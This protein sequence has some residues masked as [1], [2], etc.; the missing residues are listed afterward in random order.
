[1]RKLSLTAVRAKA[2]REG[3]LRWLRSEADERAAQAGCY[4]SAR[5]ADYVTEFFPALLQHSKGQWAG[6]PFELLDWQRDELVQPLFGWL[7]PDG[8]RRYRKAFVEIPK[9]NGKSTLAAGIGLYLL[10]GDGEQGAEVY[11]AASDR[12]QAS[13]VHGEAIRMVDASDSLSLV[14]KVNRSTHVITHPDSNSVYKALSSA[15]AG[16]EGLNAHGLIIDELHVWQGRELWDALR[17]AGRARRQPLLFVITTAGDDLTS[18]CYEQYQYA[19]GV[20]DGSIVDDRFFALIYEAQPADVEADK[21]FNR[22]VWR[23]SN[24][25][26]GST[27]DEAEF[28]RD[29]D[30]AVKTPTSRSSFLRYSFN[31]WATA[32]HPWLDLGAWIACREE[33]TPEELL[34]KRCGAGL[35]L[36]KILDTASFVLCF[37]DEDESGEAVFR[38]LPRFWLPSETAEKRKDI[39]SYQT[40]AQMGL[41]TLTEGDVCDYDAIRLHVGAASRK[42]RIHEL[43][44]DPWNAE[45][46]TQ[47]LERQYGIKRHEF[48]QTI[49]RYAHPTAEFERLIKSRALRN[50]GHLVLQWQAGHVRVKTDP[51]GNIR[52]VKQKH[53]D[54]RT[55]DGVVASIMAL[56]CALRMPK[57][58]KGSLFVV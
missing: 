38:L 50:N 48:R 57:Q 18:V 55:I 21:I 53:G 2:K 7:R 3:W 58:A 26:I 54:H 13:I 39:V 14:L 49:N 44:F 15:A 24:P 11:S 46:L 51:S 33:F 42:Y 23:S 40:W 16:K 20:L 5:H 35:D 36:A 29:V 28:G 8:T 25:S 12:D 34:G 9:K 37:P 52:P 17:Y 4:F 1:M 30:E 32:E 22:K 31:I 6:K 41:I 45:S 27:I 47:D 43:A 19:K 10:V 56:D